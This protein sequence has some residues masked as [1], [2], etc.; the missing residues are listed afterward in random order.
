MKLLSQYRCIGMSSSLGDN[1]KSNSLKS[2]SHSNKETESTMLLSATTHTLND[3]EDISR[4]DETTAKALNRDPAKDSDLCS[5]RT[6]A[7]AA[8]LCSD[9]APNKTNISERNNTD[10]NVTNK[11]IETT[12]TVNHESAIAATSSEGNNNEMV[13]TFPQR[14]RPILFLVKRPK[15]TDFERLY[16]TVLTVYS[17]RQYHISYI[18]KRELTITTKSIIA[19]IVSPFSLFAVLTKHFLI[20]SNKLIASF[21]CSTISIILHMMFGI[22]IIDHHAK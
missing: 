8:V 4:S 2:S 9:T 12:A 3:C 21:F 10:E 1:C 6:A 5:D 16:K 20:F 22:I 13:L 11:S 7:A 17:C 14:V 15:S 19:T 18:S